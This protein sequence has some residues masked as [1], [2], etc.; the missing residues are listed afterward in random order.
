[1]GTLPWTIKLYGNSH[2]HLDGGL[3]SPLGALYLEWTS[4]KPD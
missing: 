4:L 3:G 1:M 2:F